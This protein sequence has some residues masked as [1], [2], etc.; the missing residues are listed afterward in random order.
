MIDYDKINKE[1]TQQ[2]WDKIHDKNMDKFTCYYNPGSGHDLCPHPDHCIL[3][4]EFQRL[5]T[6]IQKDK[7]E[8][9][10]LDEIY[11][12]IVELHKEF[13][14]KK[15]NEFYV[16]FNPQENRVKRI[17][18]KKNIGNNLKNLKKLKTKKGGY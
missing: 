13:P 1:I 11:R 7:Q 4:E 3:N 16:G 12:D 17:S 18:L 15:F 10:K 6:Q 8:K 5:H 14:K 9:K 2:R